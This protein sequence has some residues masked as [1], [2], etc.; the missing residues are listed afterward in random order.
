MQPQHHLIVL[1]ERLDLLGAVRMQN[2]LPETPKVEINLT[3]VCGVFEQK[4]Q[5][6]ARF[7]AGFTFHKIYPIFESR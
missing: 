4:A 6:S 5:L 3:V 7:F 1:E 2:N